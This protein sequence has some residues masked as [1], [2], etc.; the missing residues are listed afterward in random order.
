MSL[1]HILEEITKRICAVSQP[2]RIILFGSCARNDQNVPNDIDLLVIMPHVEST[3]QESMRLLGA[4]RG[5]IV[6]V[7]ILVATPQQIE[8]HRQTPGLI[9]ATILQEGKIIYDTVRTSYG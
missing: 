9:Y 5:L 1:P 6:P 3:R 8:R 4:L 2:E 7:D